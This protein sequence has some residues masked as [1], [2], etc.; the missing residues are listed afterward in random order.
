MILY[1]FLS[2]D[3]DWRKQGPEKEHIFARKDRFENSVFE[4]VNQENL[5][6]NFGE[7]MDLEEKFGIRST[8]SS[9]SFSIMAPAPITVS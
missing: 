9:V 3:V 4:R 7:I 1:I 2:H 5:Y 6:Y 8:F